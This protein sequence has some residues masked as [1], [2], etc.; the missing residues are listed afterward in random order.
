[1]CPSMS[2]VSTWLGARRYA[3]QRFPI[4]IEARSV[5]SAKPIRGPLAHWQPPIAAH[6]LV[7][8]SC[9]ADA[10][11][12]I[13]SSHLAA[14]FE[15]N[16]LA[17]SAFAMRS[18]RYSQQFRA[19]PPGDERRRT[20]PSNLSVKLKRQ[21]SKQ[22][23]RPGAAD[24]RLGSTALENHVLPLA[25]QRVTSPP[26]YLRNPRDG[27]VRFGADGKVR[28]HEQI[29]P[30]LGTKDPALTPTRTIG[31]RSSTTNPQP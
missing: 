2:H 25:C 13:Q 3:S 12:A 19:L 9:K 7:D 18:A 6:P 10:I 31:R 16:H 26:L 30:H 28:P 15:R 20:A 11:Q 5:S 1:M 4:P 21:Q 24:R 23:S 17:D 27:Y 22:S 8:L 29:Y 14:I